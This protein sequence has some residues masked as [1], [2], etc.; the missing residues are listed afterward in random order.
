MVDGIQCGTVNA[1][2]FDPNPHKK[3]PQLDRQG[4]VWDV[5]FEFTPDLVLPQPL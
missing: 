4:E 5:F 3:I 2:N 1:V